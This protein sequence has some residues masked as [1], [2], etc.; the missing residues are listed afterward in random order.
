MAATMRCGTAGYKSHLIQYRCGR[1]TFSLA[2]ICI[3]AAPQKFHNKFAAYVSLAASFRR[4]WRDILRATKKWGLGLND[5]DRRAS[6][7]RKP[8][9]G[10]PNG[11]FP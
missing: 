8:V 6:E 2:V 4:A 1:F 3:G 10:S 11:T 5:R 9:R 7:A